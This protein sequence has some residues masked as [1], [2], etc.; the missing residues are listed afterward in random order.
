VQEHRDRGGLA[1]APARELRQPSCCQKGRSGAPSEFHPGWLA[2]CQSEERRD[3]DERDRDERN[4]HLLPPVLRFPHHQRELHLRAQ[5]L[6]RDTRA[7]DPRGRAVAHLGADPGPASPASGEGFHARS[8]L[9]DQL[10]RRVPRHPAPARNPDHL[11]EHP[12]PHLLAAERADPSV[13]RQARPVLVRGLRDHADLRRLHGRGVPGRHRGRPA[14]ADGS[15]PLARDEPR[16]GDEI[17][18]RPPGGA[19]GDPT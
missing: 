7:L 12:V 13:A 15:S 10:H 3:R 16:P 4:Q 18:D 5:G 19:Q 14:G 2:C 6:R 9:H 17:R 11:G 1:T 8:V